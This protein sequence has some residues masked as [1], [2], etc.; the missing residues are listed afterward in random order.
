MENSFYEEHCSDI[1]EHFIKSIIE[2]TKKFYSD[3]EFREKYGCSVE[4]FAENE[5]YKLI[6]YEEMMDKLKEM[7]KWCER[8]DY[9]S[10]VLEDVKEYIREHYEREEFLER[11]E[12]DRDGLEEELNDSCW[13]D[14]SVTGNASGSYTFNSWKA[15]QYVAHNL[16][17]LGEA[18]SEFGAENTACDILEHG[19]EWCDVTIRCYLLGQVIPQAIDE[20]VDEFSEE[21]EK[22]GEESEE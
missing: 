9:N 3:D 20:M 4:S 10:A 2:G 18:L 8:Y 21:L 17:L 12:D 14:D 7:R 6:H 5:W 11:I 1:R 19:A 22:N 16:Y 13:I 15:E